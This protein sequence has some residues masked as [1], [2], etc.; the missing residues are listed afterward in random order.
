MLFSSDDNVP[1]PRDDREFV[2]PFQLVR[3]MVL[4]AETDQ[5][6]RQSNP[7]ENLLVSAL[8]PHRVF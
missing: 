6:K 2:V 1:A 7:E 4:E 8:S 5:V 3:I